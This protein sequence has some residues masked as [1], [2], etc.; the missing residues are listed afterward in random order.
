MNKG[1]I[2]AGIDIG[3]FKIVTLIAQ[4][5]L[6]EAETNEVRILG[7]TS[8]PSQGVRK[9]QIVDIEETAAVLLSSVERAER[10][11]GF[12]IDHAIVV[13]NGG[14]I[15]CQNSHGVVAI[16]SPTGEI[17]H[18]D[19]N[20]AIDAARA[21]SLP[22]SREIIH[23]LPAEFI[24][25]QE[26]GIKDPVG[27][28]G[29]RLEVETHLITASSTALKNL[30]KCVGEVGA[31]LRGVIFSGLASSM[32]VLSDTERE[33]GVVLVDFGGGTTSIA[34]YT[35]GALVHSRV[36]PIGAKNITNDLAIGLR[37][38]LEASEKIKL[39]LSTSPKITLSK[40]SADKD[41]NKNEDEMDLVSLGIEGA[42]RSV[43]RKTLIEGIIR[44]RLNEIFS[45][46]GMELKSAGLAGRTPAGVVL[47]GGGA[48]TAGALESAKRMLALPVRIGTP[49]G[50]TGLIEEV[51]TPPFAATVGA[52]LWASRQ[53]MG[54]SSFNLDS[55][56]RTFERIPVK[57]AFGKVI[58]LVKGLL[59]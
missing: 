31:N 22:A 28:S 15:S 13:I 40:R 12:A 42:D 35:E 43:S 44:P 30:T 53:G 11:A 6:A 56:T 51:Q 34:V 20:R 58:E 16:A 27:M 7:A 45:M 37:T 26:T 9:G 21:V 59:P 24:V 1:S 10:M 36:L 48:L 39:A 29:V 4:A 25:D 2:I 5:A 32:S 57:G 14:H 55:L 47:T 54:S 49:T 33:L 3:S 19:V 17:E 23:V 52:V 50:I 41:E 18:D 38:S 46:V 8:V